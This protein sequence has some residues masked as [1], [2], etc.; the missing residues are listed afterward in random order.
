MLLNDDSA[1]DM[2]VIQTLNES[3]DQSIIENYDQLMKSGGL[4]VND[5]MAIH[6]SKVQPI[7]EEDA[8]EAARAEE[9]DA[10]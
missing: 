8:I 3:G 6:K 4:T 5:Y 1:K 7:A 2:V 10:Y 9:E